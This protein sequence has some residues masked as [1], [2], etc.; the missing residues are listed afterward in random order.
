M[1]SVV[2]GVLP[3]LL[4]LEAHPCRSRSNPPN[5]LN[6]KGSV[7]LGNEGACIALVLSSSRNGGNSLGKMKN[8]S[9]SKTF[10][11]GG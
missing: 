6:R 9:S 3:G 8:N 5:V 11:W 1:T 4:M 7:C 2:G 10:C